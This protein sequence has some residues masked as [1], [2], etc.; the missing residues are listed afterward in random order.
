MR[1]LSL[2]AAPVAA[3]RNGT[4]ALV[5]SGLLREL[6]ALHL[7]VGDPRLR[8]RVRECVPSLGGSEPV[9]DVADRPNT[10][11]K[12]ALER[13]APICRRFQRLELGELV[14]EDPEQLLRKT[15]RFTRG[16]G[17][18]ALEFRDPLLGGE[19]DLVSAMRE[20]LV[21]GLVVGERP[22]AGERRCREQRR[23]R[24]E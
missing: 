16:A 7:L 11:A 4:A 15:R 2:L 3:A 10:R 23:R 8:V 17:K 20:I 13:A 24:C 14:L 21:V 18:V 5:E 9:L 1:G 19:A 6:G 12:V 22:A